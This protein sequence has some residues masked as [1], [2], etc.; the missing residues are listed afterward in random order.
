MEY[1]KLGS[2]DITISKLCAGCMSFGKAGTMH[3]WTVDEHAT[4]AIVRHALS[5]GINF[6]DTANGYSAGT[7]FDHLHV[8]FHVNLDTILHGDGRI[9]VHTLFL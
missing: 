7:S 3:D 4:E 6:F 5:L 2:T 9:G 8:Q 1:T